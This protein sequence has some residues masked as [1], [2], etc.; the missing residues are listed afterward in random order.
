MQNITNE[1]CSVILSNLWHK[2]V[3]SPKTVDQ[4]LSEIFKMESM[5]QFIGVFGGTD[6]WDIPIKCP[7][8]GNE[9]RKEYYNFKNFYFIVMMGINAAGYKF[10]WANV[11]LPGRVNGACI[12]QAFHSYSAIV[13][14][15]VLPDIKI[16][17]TAQSQREV[18]LPPILLGG[19]AFPHHSWLQK[20]FSH[21][22]LSEKESHF[23]YCLSGARMVRECTFGQL[24]RRQRLLYRKSEARQHSLKMSVLVY[25]MLS[26]NGIPHNIIDC[27]RQVTAECALIISKL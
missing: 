17:L 26:S 5:W 1:V 10:L 21:I 23:D 7:H 27:P 2:F 24:K 3:I 16:I 9:A 19:S 20:Q 12:F 8:G 4:I 22:V 25:I 11:Q 13:R 18:Q 15:N 6:G 14:G